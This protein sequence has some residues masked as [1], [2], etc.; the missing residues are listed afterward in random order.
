MTDAIK[1][2]R[3]D[4]MGLV[5]SHGADRWNTG[6]AE[7]SH[8]NLEAKRYDKQAVKARDKITAAMT[9]LLA[10]L[11]A[12]EAK[13][14]ADAARS[15]RV[16]DAARVYY[17]RYAQDEAADGDTDRNWTGCSAQ[18]SRHAIELRDSLK[19]ISAAIAQG[20]KP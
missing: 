3:E 9:E 13:A 12:A 11:D 10:R 14:E 6:C 19:E 5:D 7:T 15:K 20:V 1:Q 18:Q 17:Q 8:N 4:F 16:V 2:M